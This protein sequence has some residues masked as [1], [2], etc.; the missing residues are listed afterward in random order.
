MRSYKHS[1]VWLATAS[2]LLA[3]RIALG[4][5][6]TIDYK[7]P[8]DAP[9]QTL[10]LGDF[11]PQPMDQNGDKWMET[12]FA[13]K[14]EAQKS[15]L[16]DCLDLHW[17]QTIWHDDAPAEIGGNIPTFPV[18]DPPSGGWDYQNNTGS[19]GVDNDGDGM[20]DE[21]D[22]DIGADGNDNDGD[23]MVDEVGE[24]GDDTAPWYWNP[25]EESTYNVDMQSYEY[26]DNPFDTPA[27]GYTGFST[28]LVAVASNFCDD[29][30]AMC[31]AAGEMLVL[32]GFDWRISTAAITVQSTFSA[33]TAGDL[34][35][36]NVAMG[37]SGFTG[38]TA[39]GDKVI[40]C[41]PEPSTM[42]ML[43]L[44]A[45]I[46]AWRRKVVAHEH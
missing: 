37:N 30:D 14:A 18:I 43:V 13:V 29:A 45:A 36:I 44:S 11:T 16:W 10:A 42:G 2:L 38:W 34:A 5:A 31:L 1:L 21:A 24:T 8:C 39:V 17:L 22:E 23:G 27:P 26:Y 41:V 20:T 40:C 3:G 4:V 32:G 28:Y 12:T 15:P 19:D 35:E 25:A 46:V 6:I 9:T 33:P 7:I